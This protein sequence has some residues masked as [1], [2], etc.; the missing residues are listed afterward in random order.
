MN[1]GE[2][3]GVNI[4][5]MMGEFAARVQ[6]LTAVST[7]CPQRLVDQV[8]GLEPG[9]GEVAGSWAK[10]VG[11]AFGVPALTVGVSMQGSPAKD[12]E[13]GDYR[14]IGHGLYGSIRAIL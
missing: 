8:G 14:R 1:S 4:E 9:Y 2:G 5:K 3:G 13:I 6:T 7:E 11:R 12:F 10:W